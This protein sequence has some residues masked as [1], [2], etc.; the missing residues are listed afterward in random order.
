MLR[1]F[2]RE[3]VTLFVDLDDLQELYPE[4]VEALEQNT[5]R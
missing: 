4:I 1:I 2:E 5:V 3:E